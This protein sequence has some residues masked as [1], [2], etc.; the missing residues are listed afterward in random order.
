MMPSRRARTRAARSVREANN[1]SSSGTCLSLRGVDA[2]EAIPHRGG[3]SGQQHPDMTLR[4][5]LTSEGNSRQRHQV[6]AARGKQHAWPRRH[7]GLESELTRDPEF[8]CGFRAL[9]AYLVGE[10]HWTDAKR[11]LDCRPARVHFDA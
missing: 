8:P 11:C 3:G 6:V 4:L 5:M 7:S 9:V 1:P 2:A 10:I